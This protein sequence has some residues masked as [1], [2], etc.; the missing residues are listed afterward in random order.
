[1]TFRSVGEIMREVHHMI[2]I[3][4]NDGLVLG[5]QLPMELYESA[6]VDITGGGDARTKE[7]TAITKAIHSYRE[8]FPLEEVSGLPQG[9]QEASKVVTSPDEGDL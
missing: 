8:W 9:S 3:E 5:A 4:I 6:G 2:A 1:M 7:S